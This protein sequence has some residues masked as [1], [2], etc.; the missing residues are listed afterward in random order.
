MQL[1]EARNIKMNAKYGYNKGFPNI[2]K[3]LKFLYKQS[4]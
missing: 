4:E 3:A 1:I 2:L